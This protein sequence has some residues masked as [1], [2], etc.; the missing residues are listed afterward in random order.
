MDKK[1]KPIRSRAS[2]EKRKDWL[3]KH[4]VQKRAEFQADNP[5]NAPL[6][7]GPHLPSAPLPQGPHLPAQR[8]EFVTCRSHLQGWTCVTTFYPAINRRV[9]QPGDAG[10]DEL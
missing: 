10:Y 1:S 3:Q 8:P 2:E 7:Q 9:L 4:V 5:P 6:P